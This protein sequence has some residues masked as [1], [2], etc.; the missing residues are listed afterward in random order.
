MADFGPNCPL[1]DEGCQPVQPAVNW[2]TVQAVPQA[3]G[4]LLLPWG[5]A[6]ER[7]DLLVLPQDRLRKEGRAT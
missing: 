1:S 7:S 5:K 2:A 4:L 3:V 6:A